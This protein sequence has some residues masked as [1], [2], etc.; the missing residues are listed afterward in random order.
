[1]VI[2]ASMGGGLAGLSAAYEFKKSR[3]DVTL[4]EAQGDPRGKISLPA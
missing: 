3:C 2:R 1:M 4:L